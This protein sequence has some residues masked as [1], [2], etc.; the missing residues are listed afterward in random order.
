MRLSVLVSF[1]VLSSVEH[2]VSQNAYIK[3]GQQAYI[4]GNFKAAIKQLEKG[5]LIDSTNANALWMLGYSYYHSD[6]YQK[7]IAAFTKELALEPADAHAYYYRARAQYRLGIESQ[8]PAEKEKFLLGAIIDLTKAISINP[9]NAKLAVFYQNRGIAY[10]EY[11]LFRLQSNQRFF[12]RARGLNALKAS[13]N[14]LQ[15]IYDVDRS[16]DDIAALIE[17]SKQKLSIAAATATIPR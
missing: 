14:D 3:L 2:A 9:S 16:R 7:S 17:L 5:R 11:G 6:N 4:D 13:V 12:D 1:L 8:I 15:K 10:R